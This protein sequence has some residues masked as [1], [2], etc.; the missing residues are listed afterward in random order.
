[1]SINEQELI[2]CAYA[3]KHMYIAMYKL[4]F[5]MSVLVEYLLE[6]S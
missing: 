5:S 2:V 1:M 3:T 6:V 4:F